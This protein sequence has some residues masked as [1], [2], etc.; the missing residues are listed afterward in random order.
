MNTIKLSRKIRFLYRGL[1]SSFLLKTICQ[2]EFRLRETLVVMG[3]TRSG[4]TWLT[5]LVNAIPKSAVIFEPISPTH[6]P[7]AAKAGFTYDTYKLPNDFW[8]QGQ[9]FM[10]K[11]L[12]GKIITPWTASQIPITTACSAQR[13]I[14]KFVRGNMLIGWLTKNFP[15]QP[16]AL[17]IRHP[18][19]T[20]FSHLRK[21]W[22]P[23]VAMLL[24]N[25]FFKDKKETRKFCEGL[26]YPEEFS[27]LRWCMR[28]Y[29]PLA[30][31][32]RPFILVSYERLVRNGRKELEKIFTTWNIPIPEE[33]FLRL[34]RPSATVA[35][36]S[37]V[38][39]G[40]DPLCGWQ[41]GLSRNQVKRILNV[42]SFF[43][44]DFFS[45]NVE[46]DYDRLFT[47]IPRPLN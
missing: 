9:R 13:L 4:T 20:V 15:I 3:S 28:Y 26:K 37:Q 5:E 39:H 24:N 38:I 21:G 12:S 43:G 27:A 1:I 17:I 41:E 40:S 10:K 29:V 42:A 35:K 46:P 36:N 32:D 7:E 14:V 11:V 45:E 30:L 33:A 22:I 25:P 19:A 44:L 23:N 18:C 2:K 47:E 8:P 34:K 6:V 16:P 31:P